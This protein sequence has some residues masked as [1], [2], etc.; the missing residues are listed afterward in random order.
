MNTIDRLYIEL[1]SHGLAALRNAM[2]R[3]AFEYC[4]CESEHL[5]E[6]PSLIGNNNMAVHEFYLTV[7]RVT[8]T[9]CINAIGGSGNAFLDR[10]Y[11]HLWGEL[12]RIVKSERQDLR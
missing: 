7:T 6:V 4:R 2:Q 1:L 9:Q 3:G 12:E 10:R 8:Y 5:H 11:A